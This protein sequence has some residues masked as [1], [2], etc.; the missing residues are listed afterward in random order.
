VNPVVAVLLGTVLLGEPLT[1]RTLV[2]GGII[3]ASVALIVRTPRR[4]PRTAV[5]PRPAAVAVRGR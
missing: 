4:G 2:G 3:I 5:E 1:W